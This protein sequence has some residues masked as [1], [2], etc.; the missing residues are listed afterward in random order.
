MH[1]RLA[2]TGSSWSRVFKGRRRSELWDKNLNPHRFNTGIGWENSAT[3]HE[4]GLSW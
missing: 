4:R 2:E 3:A 1:L